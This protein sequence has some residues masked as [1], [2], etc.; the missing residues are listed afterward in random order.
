VLDTYCIDLMRMRRM[1]HPQV[2]A[3]SQIGRHP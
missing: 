3:R 1:R 2:G